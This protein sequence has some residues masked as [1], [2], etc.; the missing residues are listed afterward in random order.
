MQSQDSAPVHFVGRKACPV[1]S[2]G[3]PARIYECSYSDDPVRSLITSHFAGQGE[4]DWT[5]LKSANF[6]V[7][8]C[9]QCDLI[10]QT[11][12]PGD[13]LLNTIYTRMIRPKNL[14]EYESGLL[15]LDNYQRISG[16]FASIFRKLGKPI[17][18]IRVL[19]YGMGMGRWARVARGMGAKVYATEIGADKHRHGVSL[20]IQ[21]LDDHKIDGMTFD[22]IHT[23]QVCEHLVHP[24]RDFAR[25]TKTL[26]PGGLFKVAI[27]F[28]GRLENILRAGKLHNV[29]L[30]AT[31]GARAIPGDAEA[32]GAIQPLEH[33]NAF[34]SRTIDWLACE[35]GLEV[36]AQ[37]RRRSI[38]INT[39]SLRSFAT[40]MGQLGVE[41]AKAAMRLRV[42]YYL[43]RKP[44]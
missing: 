4:V 33:L 35:N 41:L 8:H 11:E 19:D 42:G 23:E 36:I 3:D 1:C 6:F 39:D 24:G 15:T 12:V 9:R 30:F 16:E 22:L 13:D 29:S 20:G 2:D 17:G 14:E 5:L 32:C 26:A 38:A 31:E 25:L 7:D 43:L 28:R 44:R 10:Y 21:M 18:E 40:A 34:S 37:T 27:P